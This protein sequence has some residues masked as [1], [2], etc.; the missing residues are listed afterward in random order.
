VFKGTNNTINAEGYCGTLRILHT[1]I[2]KKYHSMLIIGV[3]VLPHS[4]VA[5]AIQDMLQS[6]C[7]KMFD[8]LLYSL[9]LSLC[10]FHM[11][12]PLKYSGKV[13]HILVGNKHQG[14]SG[15]AVLEQQPRVLFVEGIH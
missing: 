2:K 7:C 14:C 12:S 8:S 1:V 13:L 11:F 3:C 15:P 4:H 5:H 9:E 6:L 10:D